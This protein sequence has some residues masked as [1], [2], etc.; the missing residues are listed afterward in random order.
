MSVMIRDIIEQLGE[1]KVLY[2]TL[3]WLGN[4]KVDDLIQDIIIDYDLEFDA[5]DDI[6]T[7]YMS[8]Y[9]NDKLG[10]FIAPNLTSEDI[11][12][13][14]QRESFYDIIDVGDSVVRER[15]FQKMADDLNLDYN[16]I[17]QLW[18]N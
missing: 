18:R 1:E 14:M 2:Y 5:E 13:R 12:N 16:D 8:E 3:K 6:K 10:D 4:D 9:P 11:L 17:Y 7:W 15:I